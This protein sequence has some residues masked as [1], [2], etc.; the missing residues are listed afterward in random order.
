LQAAVGAFISYY[1]VKIVPYWGLSLIATSILFLV[2]LVYTTNKEFIDHHISHAT[3]VVNAQTAQIKDVASKHTAQATEV[4]KQ[5]LGDYTSKAQQA[6]GVRTKTGSPDIAAKTA[7][8][9]PKETDFPAAPKGDF[10]TAAPVA[11]VS[12]S[13]KTDEPALTQT[14]K[15]PLIAT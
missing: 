6:I 9:G 3:N 7:K 1:L 11:P 5:Y 12:A 10:T 15:E 14:Q 2:P 4:T 13:T 8:P